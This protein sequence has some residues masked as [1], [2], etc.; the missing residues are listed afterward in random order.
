MCIRDSDRGVG[1]RST[2]GGANAPGGANP[3]AAGGL[4]LGVVG[5]AGAGAYLLRA[6]HA[7]TPKDER[8]A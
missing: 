4:A 2:G 7:G 1:D 5:L 6:R 3:W 8:K